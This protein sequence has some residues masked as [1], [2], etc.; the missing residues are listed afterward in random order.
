MDVLI[1][2]EHSGTVRNAFTAAGHNATSIDIEKSISPGK[3]IIEDIWHNLHKYKADLIIAHPPCTYLCRAQIPL[4]FNSKKRMSA[5]L[6]SIFWTKKIMSL[7]ADMICIENP[8][9]LLN[10][11]W[12]K[13]DQI[14]YPWQFGNDHSKDICLWTKNLPPLMPVALSSGRRPMS[15]HTNSSMTQHQRMLRRSRFFPEVAQAMATQWG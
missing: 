4:C 1:L 5:A 9:G 6:R 2:F 8:I 15:N 14:I 10:T 7:N 11:A 3:H 13:P 12:R